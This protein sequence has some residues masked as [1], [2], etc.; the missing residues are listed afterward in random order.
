MWS[1]DEFAPMEA[2]PT[3]VCLTTYNG[4]SEDFMRMPFQGLVEQVEAG[5]LRVQIGRTFQLDQIVEAH[6]SMEENRAD[7]KIVVLTAV[8]SHR[9]AK[10][11]APVLDSTRDNT[12]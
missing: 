2:I 3:A 7:G 12:H 10:A 9:E 11:T 6:R 4:D 1:F 8:N 5:T